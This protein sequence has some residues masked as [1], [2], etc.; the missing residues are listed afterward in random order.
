M[1][2]TNN[3]TIFMLQR[4]QLMYDTSLDEK[5]I[6]ALGTRYLPIPSGM[7]ACEDSKLRET[8][9]NTYKG[10]AI[11]H[12]YVR[13]TLNN[14]NGLFQR[15]PHTITAPNNLDALIKSVDGDNLIDVINRVFNNQVTYSRYG[16]LL[17]VADN[18][19][20]YLSEYNAS[21]ITNYNK[22]NRG[23][24]NKLN[25][26]IL[27][28]G[29]DDYLIL[30]V[31]KVYYQLRRNGAGVRAFNPDDE[32]PDDAIV[33]SVNGKPLDFIPFVFVNA[34]DLEESVQMPLLVDLAN[35][36]ISLYRS[37]ADYQQ[38]LFMSSQATPWMTGVSKDT[39]VTLG[40]N[41]MLTIQDNEAKVGFLEV[42]GSG[43]KSQK[44][45]I[46]SLK[47]DC[48]LIGQS[49]ASGNASESGVALSIRVGSST[50]GLASIA[51][52][53]ARV[54]YNLL[55]IAAEWYGYDV[56]EVSVEANT[57]YIVP[58]AKMSD[59]SVLSKLVTEGVFSRVDYYK[60]LYKNELTEFSTFE[61][62]VS[63]LKAVEER[64]NKKEGE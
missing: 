22:A 8:M 28:E 62:W 14:M 54:F 16:V 32:M 20:L 52:T 60:Y 47:T 24:I 37:E 25:C 50:A 43:L 57:D 58:Q 7:Y 48:D 17:D 15:N 61:E 2:I 42:A 55:T 5:H 38:A 11:Y 46:D 56:N 40:S 33:P 44:D 34:T 21:N 23:G 6:K 13:K 19:E 64:S 49:I 45:N 63:N 39:P 30:A 18:G 35:K 26:I 59:V 36:C 9:Y 29:H 12:N 41:T 27:K 3:D 53:N 51:K 31:D 10:R 1:E 4:W